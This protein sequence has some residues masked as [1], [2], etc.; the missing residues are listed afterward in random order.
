MLTPRENL[1][2]FGHQKQ[3]EVLL[4][5]FHSE[6]FPHGWII[7]GPVGIG[8]AT[9]VFH[10]A[11][12]IL[13]GR[14]DGNTTFDESEPFHRRIVAQSH[15]DLWTLGDEET[16]EIGVESVRELNGFLN[17]TSAEEGWRVVIIDGADRLNRNAA[18]ALLKRLEEPPPRTVFFLITPF[19]G[20]LLPTIRSRCQ[21][22]ALNP[23]NEAE[24]R[25]VLHSQGCVSPDFL[26]V[27]QGSPGHLMRLMEGKGAQIYEDLQRVLMG[28]SSTSFI[29]THGGDET[30]YAL[31]EDLVRNYLH[32]HLLAKAEERSS[33]FEGT[34]LEYALNVCDKIKELFDQCGLA[35]L[36]KKVTLTCA[37][38]TLESKNSQ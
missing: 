33:F 6:R 15:G 28:E 13:S 2:L 19:T 20:R 36:D 35:Q 27:A 29:H 25:E 22:L 17:Q 4:R 37:F 31:I 12:Y 24:C 9:F 3:R 5:A 1:K 21:V 23:L 26:P 8:K 18:N 14:Q 34:S 38:A 30:S 32:T 16:R 7:A 10:M 11:R